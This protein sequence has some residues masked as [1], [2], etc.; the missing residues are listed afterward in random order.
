MPKVQIV[1]KSCHR[2][3]LKVQRLRNFF[4]GNGYTLVKDNYEID[5][6]NK[7]AFPLQDLVIDPDA[8]LIVLTTCG[9]T[10]AIEDGDFQAL[11]II[12][13]NMKPTAQI[14][15]A[16]CIVKINPERVALEFDG[17][18]FDAHSYE[19]INDILNPVVPF[20]NFEEPNQMLHTDKFFIQIQ[21]GCS[22][23]CT[24]CAIWK[25]LGKSVSKPIDDV[26]RELHKG[27]KEGHRKFYLIGECAGQY[28]RDFDKD[29][30]DLLHEFTQVKNNFTLVLEDVSPKYALKSFEPLKLLFEQKKMELFH[31]PIQSGN[32]R[33]LKLMNRRTDMQAFKSMCRELKEIAPE[34]ILSSAVIVGF[35]SETREELQD[36]I[37]YCRDARFD[38]VACHMFSARPG[39]KAATMPD[40]I[41]HEELVARYKIFQS[42][43]GGITRIDPNQ[44]KFVE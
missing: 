29:L 25:T 34:S 36:S 30:G 16:G 6:T 43:F 20:Q 23:R 18:T 19:K 1:E 41:P 28:G 2:E 15:V 7:Y 22:N 35:P 42:E 3:G 10:Q 17:P 44:R 26:M 40:Q 27:L 12:R 21:S 32:D 38:S 4:I 37:D 31:S 5:P 14:I 8:D 9:F 39:A 24:Y 11:D 33:I 13:K